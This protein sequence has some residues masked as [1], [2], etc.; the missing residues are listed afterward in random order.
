MYNIETEYFLLNEPKLKPY[1][2]H[3]LENPG[4][5][6]YN[7]FIISCNEF[8]GSLALED[9]K[10]DL[11]AKYP[12]REVLE[13]G[14]YQISSFIKSS[15]EELL[16]NFHKLH[17]SLLCV[18]IFD[19]ELCTWNYKEQDKLAL[20]LKSLIKNKIQVA[21]STSFIYGHSCYQDSTIPSGEMWSFFKSA[22]EY[23]LPHNRV[24]YKKDLTGCTLTLEQDKKRFKLLSRIIK[25]HSFGDLYAGIL[26]ND[27]DLDFCATMQTE[28]GLSILGGFKPPSY[29]FPR[30]ICPS[31]GKAKLIPYFCI[32]SVLSGCHVIKFHCLNCKDRFATNQA[33]DY[34]RVI[35][36]YGTRPYY[37]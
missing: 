33:L 36:Y 1:L 6:L 37:K 7:G 24:I 18:F 26:T 3:I 27:S 5:P 15:P 16:K 19:L 12:G 34:Y 20:F 35:R 17:P 10:N 29:I 14:E 2:N 22:Q 23:I 13:Y 31:C 4:D 25:T 32:A 9:L 21:V 30:A 28:I 8:A 11:K